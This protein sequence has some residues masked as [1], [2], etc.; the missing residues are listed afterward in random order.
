M[1]LSQVADAA[2]SGKG[3]LGQ[4]SNIIGLDGGLRDHSAQ[5]FLPV[6]WS[7]I[8][9]DARI[10][11]LDRVFEARLVSWSGTGHGFFESA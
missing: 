3:I 4:G 2:K 5:F 9:I 11:A 1:T 8:R 10:R 7:I 6:A